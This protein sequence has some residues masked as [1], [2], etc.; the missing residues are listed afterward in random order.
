MT[1]QATSIDTTNALHQLHKLQRACC[2]NTQTEQ[3]DAFAS[4][5]TKRVPPKGFQPKETI[6][7]S[8]MERLEDL[9]SSEIP[10]REFNEKALAATSS[11]VMLNKEG[12]DFPLKD[13]DYLKMLSNDNIDKKAPEFDSEWRKAFERM[14]KDLLSHDRLSPKA[15]TEILTDGT[16][17]RDVQFVI[18]ATMLMIDLCIA[19]NKGEEKVAKIFGIEPENIKEIT[20]EMCVLEGKYEKLYA[21]ANPIAWKSFPNAV[22]V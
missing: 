16:S 11:I 8:T 9:S 18:S 17:R 20:P 21:F 6:P 7:L 13:S 1:C 14:T 2:E 10:E 12:L 4:S 19:K 22:K 3:N 15:I 5:S